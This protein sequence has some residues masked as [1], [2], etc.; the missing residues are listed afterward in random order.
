MTW[1][2]IPMPAPEE[3]V[4]GFVPSVEVSGTGFAYSL[5]GLLICLPAVI[6][7]TIGVPLAGADSAHPDDASLSGEITD[8][9]RP[10]HATLAKA[11]VVAPRSFAFECS[12]DA[13]SITIVERG[14]FYDSA[15]FA[16][17]F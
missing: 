6:G 14:T 3:L 2:I 10:N 7:L 1:N 12:K 4:S 8:Q 16:P 15:P 11:N 9:H 5:R 13:G 17:L